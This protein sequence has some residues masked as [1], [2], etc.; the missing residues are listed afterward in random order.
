MQK[1]PRGLR[2]F[3]EPVEQRLLLSQASQ[4]VFT[5]S[6]VSQVGGN[7]STLSVELLDS[8]GNPA[9]AATGGQLIN[10]ASSSS[11][12][13]FLSN[14]NYITNITISAGSDSASFQYQDSLNGTP[15]LTASATGLNSAT[16]QETITASVDPFLETSGI[17]IRNNR[18][19]GDNVPLQGVNLGGYLLME[20]WMTP[21]DNSGLP[22]D[23]SVLQTLDNRF[24]VA[25]EQSLITT[26]QQH[27][28]T[29]TDLDNIKAMGINVIRLPFWW[30]DLETLSGVWRSDAFAQMDWLINQAWQRGIYTILD[31]HGVVGGQSTDQDTAESG[32]NQYWTS[33][34]DQTA[35][36]SIW[37]KIAAHYKGNPA[38]AGYDLINEPT[39]APSTTAVW[40]AYNTLYHEIR[41]IDP[42]HMIIMEGTFGNWDWN[43]LP[44][45]TAYGWT[46]VVYEMHEYQ[47]NSSNDPSAIEA[48][49]NNQVSDFD[50]HLSWNVPDYVGEFNDFTAGSN[51]T[52]VWQ[53]TIQQFDNNNI[54]WSM[55]SYKTTQT[56]APNGW[57]I[58]APTFWAQTPNIQTDSAA[59]IARDWSEWTT[60]ATFTVTT[61]L[62]KSLAQ[63]VP[64]NNE[65]GVSENGSL[66]TTAASGVLANDY[67]INLGQT[68][69]QLSA[70]L[71]DSTA[72]GVLAFNSDGS[73][74]YTPNAGFVGAD[75]F[76]YRVYDGYANSSS[77]A[78]VTFQVNAS[79]FPTGWSESDI[80]LPA[81]SGSAQ[82]NSAVN[83]WT[84]NGG[85]AGIG[86]GSDQ[87][88]YSYQLLPSNGRDRS[89]GYDTPCRQSR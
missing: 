78:T 42:N 71:V 18:G 12:G 50:N 25:E 37:E 74:T 53:Y 44:D 39:G 28:I 85:G 36:A 5:T 64:V 84:I 83:T 49:T 38:V 40:N 10:L 19:T 77:L 88:N 80:G 22:D 59:T 66:T 56:L 11:E 89:I 3:C 47:F 52:S 7:V 41:S 63:P 65:Y 20:G 17:F 68:G 21:M 45:P 60:T 54:N 29:T 43:Q 67:D 72:H 79:T 1:Q 9:A 33:S 82:F 27:W 51:P 24:G 30:G 70:T 15:M 35:T 75:I 48:G 87:F 62:Q 58:Y 8:T 4:I 26:Y 81:L 32:L 2:F 14:N 61:M 23:Y 57:G 73:F 34:A 31:F 46:N 16:Q 86:S 6:A 13:F 69:I 55:W 76:R